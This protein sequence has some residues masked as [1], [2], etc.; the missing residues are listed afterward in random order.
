M[1]GK[2]LYHLKKDHWSVKI[3]IS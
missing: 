3:L 2:T 1:Q